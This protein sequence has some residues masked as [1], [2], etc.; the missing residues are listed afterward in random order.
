[1]KKPYLVICLIVIGLACT[2]IWI[3]KKTPTSDENTEPFLPIQPEPQLDPPEEVA[4]V[5]KLTKK[6]E[7]LQPI[8]P[9][10][11]LDPP[12]EVVNKKMKHD[13][14]KIM[15]EMRE[16]RL[17]RYRTEY[18]DLFALLGL[19][20]A[21]AEE[22]LQLLMEGGRERNMRLEDLLGT[23][24]FMTYKEYRSKLPSEIKMLKERKIAMKEF[25]E[26]TTRDNIQ[27]AQ[28]DYAD[29]I[30]Q[31]AFTEED[32]QRFTEQFANNKLKGGMKKVLADDV[33]Q[34][35][36]QY[37][38]QLP[39]KK[40]TKLVSAFLEDEGQA[41]SQDQFEKLTQIDP[42]I[43]H[44]IP[45]PGEVTIVK[46]T[47]LKE[48]NADEI[49]GNKAYNMT[50]DFIKAMDYAE[51]ILTPEQMELYAL[52]LEKQFEDQKIINE[53]AKKELNRSLGNG[54]SREDLISIGIH[55]HPSQVRKWKKN[56]S[57][58][59]AP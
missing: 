2:A 35:Y 34:A 30:Q 5:K 14:E 22:F 19:T 52:Y 44:S 47:D 27:K 31:M 16:R 29:F 1:M 25:R 48:G 4:P 3:V 56:L 10:P 6:A 17:L 57:P 53:I 54:R 38:K 43:A 49:A 23:D 12:K 37:K 40:H 33:F 58:E 36:M 11:Q 46:F 55:V 8:P 28:I 13:H 42:T 41:L 9:E 32:A 24:D 26:T 51:T 39:A 45:S 50:G 7:I 15:E 59:T 20:E 21:Q 18:A